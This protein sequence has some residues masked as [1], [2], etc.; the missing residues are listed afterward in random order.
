VC[1]GLDD[2]N[3]LVAHGEVPFGRRHPALAP[4]GV[5]SSTT[6]IADPQGAIDGRNGR[7]HT[8][9]SAAARPPSCD[10]TDGRGQARD[11]LRM[12]DGAPAADGDDAGVTARRAR[13]AEVVERETDHRSPCNAPPARWSASCRRRCRRQ[14]QSLPIGRRGLARRRTTNCDIGGCVV[15]LP[16]AADELSA[17]LLGTE[18]AAGNVLRW[19]AH[20][21]DRAVLAVNAI[22]TRAS[23]TMAPT[24]RRRN[25]S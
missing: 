24:M 13:Q 19:L 15:V 16:D 14:A 6:S 2:S 5:T 4:G 8:F 18:R 22:T 9:R 11:W 7:P 17:G 10:E 23:R 12:P 1:E 21:D 25:S 20:P 3:V